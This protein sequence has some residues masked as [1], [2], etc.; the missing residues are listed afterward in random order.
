MVKK[1]TIGKIQLIVGILLLIGSILSG[2]YIGKDSQKEFNLNSENFIRNLEDFQ[3]QNFTT[4]DSKF[5]AS[6][7]IAQLYTTNNHYL[8]LRLAILESTSLIIFIMSILFIT[9]GLVNIRQT[10][11]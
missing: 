5:I 6:F 9:Q 11:K 1:E 7:E 3:N 10:N 2:I 8:K 4:E